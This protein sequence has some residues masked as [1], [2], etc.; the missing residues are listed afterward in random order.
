[1]RAWADANGVAPAGAVTEQYRIGPV[2]EP[3][4]GR[5]ETELAYEAWPSC[6]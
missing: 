2:E 1:M 6:S 4:P 5:W 3:G